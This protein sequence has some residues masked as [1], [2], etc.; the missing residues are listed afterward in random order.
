MVAIFGT[1]QGNTQKIPGKNVAVFGD[2]FMN[3]ALEFANNQ[4][5]AIHKETAA[6]DGFLALSSIMIFTGDDLLF[7]GNQCFARHPGRF[8]WAN[9]LL[10]GGTL[11]AVANSWFE[12]PGT[13]FFSAA[14]FGMMNTTTDNHST[15]CLL[16]RG[17]LFI[18]SQNLTMIDAAAAYDVNGNPI[19]SIDG[20]IPNPESIC[21]RL[22]AVFPPVVYPI[23]KSTGVA[24][25]GNMTGNMIANFR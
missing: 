8:M 11:R 19:R 10:A 13:E 4:V 1:Q 14:T 3:G 24:Q 22:N 18:D 23:E 17:S 9:A 2:Q 6:K 5:E 12:H 20:N 16:V 15:H 25:P 21:R 7:L